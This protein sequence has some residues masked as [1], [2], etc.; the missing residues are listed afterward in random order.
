MNK[1]ING[2]TESQ[3]ENLYRYNLQTGSSIM[4]TRSS[5]IDPLNIRA[6]PKS[7][8]VKNITETPTKVLRAT[9]MQEKSHTV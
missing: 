6:N 8:Q 4:V 5:S 3:N 9:L 7:H 1:N 2:K